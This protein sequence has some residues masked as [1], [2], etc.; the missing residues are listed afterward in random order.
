MFVSP[1]RRVPTAKACPDSRAEK[2]YLWD[3][4]ANFGV[5]WGYP[6]HR[7]IE[8]SNRFYAM[9]TLK[10]NGGMQHFDTTDPSLA[11]LGHAVFFFTTR[12]AR[13]N[14]PRRQ[15]RQSRLAALLV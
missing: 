9:N 6:N 5:I 13:T 12:C 10:L 1:P 15:R 3:T 11:E 4:S 7:E 14:I 8:L 2:T